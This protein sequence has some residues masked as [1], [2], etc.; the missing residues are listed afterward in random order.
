VSYI[1]AGKSQ[2]AL[3]LTLDI[4]NRDLG[5]KR[6]L[7]EGGGGI[8]GAFMRAGLDDKLNLILRPA[9]DGAKGAKPGRFRGDRG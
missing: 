6:L 4:L 5:V 7:L 8:N 9:V 3:D 2:L 1:F